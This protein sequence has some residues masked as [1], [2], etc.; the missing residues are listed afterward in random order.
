MKVISA[1]NM[2]R[3]EE[4]ANANGLSYEVMMENAGRNAAKI[5]AD[6]IPYDS[7][8]TILCGKGKNGGD[9]FVIAGV[10]KEYGFADIAVILALG[11]NKNELCIKM[12]EKYLSG[13]DV[14]NYTDRPQICLNR[15]RASSVIVDAVFG[16]GFSGKIE[17]GIV[18]LFETAN[19]RGK[20]R[21]AIDIPSGINADGSCSGIYFRSDLTI[22]MHAFKPAHVFAHTMCGETVSADIGLTP[23][24]DDGLCESYTTITRSELDKLIEPRRN[25]ANKG[26]FGKL[27]VIAGSYNMSGAAYFSSRAA[28]ESGAG[29]VYAAFPDSIYQSLAPRLSEPLMVA[30][31]SDNNGGF[32]ARSISRIER[33]INKSSAAALG[34]GLG[35]GRGAVELT[36]FI[37][38]NSKIPLVLDADGINIAAMNKDILREATCDIIMIP[39]PGEMARLTGLSISEIQSNRTDIAKKFAAEY[40]V[41]LVL[42]GANTVVCSP[43]GRVFINSAGNPGLAR[44]GSGDVLCGITGAM[45]CRCKNTFDAACAAVYIHSLAADK[46]RRELSEESVTPSRLLDNIGLVFGA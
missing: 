35:L 11:E 10:L 21:I 41:T 39:H 30:C 26:D 5:I 14:M 8:I 46:I 18:P 16:I 20:T 23:D 28:V 15:I 44:G 22:T 4:K 45:L 33:I 9:G 12:N 40:S 34:C 37:I 36:E 25:D 43:D 27:A 42:K 6:S 2:R 19:L 7:S 38:K 29:I 31:E 13:I 1:Q 24:A 3:A 17:G 32:S